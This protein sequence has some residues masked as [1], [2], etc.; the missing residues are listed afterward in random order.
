M[1]PDEENLFEQAYVPYVRIND[2]VVP[3]PIIHIDQDYL[4]NMYR[5]YARDGYG[6]EM[7]TEIIYLSDTTPFTTQTRGLRIFT[8]ACADAINRALSYAIEHYIVDRHTLVRIFSE[9]GSLTTDAI[10]CLVEYTARIVRE[11]ELTGRIQPLLWRTQ[12]QQALAFR[13]DIHTEELVSV[14]ELLESRE[15]ELA[16]TA[17][18]D[19]RPLRFE[20]I[21]SRIF[22][23]VFSEQN[24]TLV[25][26]DPAPFSDE[27][28]N[29]LL[30]EG[31]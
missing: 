19:V 18:D 4:E 21:G 13:Q 23:P 5:I 11:Y 28:L 1:P 26:G 8:E 22:T 29:T 17:Q 10:T 30:F 14:E 7:R 2:N 31:A 25:E 27:D 15:R 16:I 3:I 20:H 6:R 9:S 12:Q 24:A